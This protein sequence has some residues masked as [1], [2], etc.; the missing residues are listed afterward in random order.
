[1]W[2]ISTGE[3]GHQARGPI[4]LCSRGYQKSIIEKE[5][6]EQ[7]KDQ[8]MLWKQTK[9]SIL[10]AREILSSS[11]SITGDLIRERLRDGVK[12]KTVAKNGTG[13][14][15]HQNGD[16]ARIPLDETSLDILKS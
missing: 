10:E 6:E 7:R 3:L 16:Y 9:E 12:Q 14:N 15:G 11:D 13:K 2:L 8:G 4:F 1:L 5:L